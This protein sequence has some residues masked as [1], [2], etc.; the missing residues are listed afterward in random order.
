M[1]LSPRALGLC[2]GHSYAPAGTI[3]F[4]YLP[5]GGDKRTYE[6]LIEAFNEEYPHITVKVQQWVPWQA[7]TDL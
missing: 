7:S 6:T 1:H 4:A 3:T 5:F 2:P